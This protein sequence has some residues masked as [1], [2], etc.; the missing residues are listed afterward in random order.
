MF[1]SRSRSVAASKASASTAAFGVPPV[2]EMCRSD[3]ANARNSPKESHRR[4]FSACTCCTCFGAEPPAPVSNKPPPAINGTIDS[5]FAEV[6]N[7]RM[8]NRSVL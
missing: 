4:W 6:P 5:I 8:G 2:F 3:S 7:S 1:S